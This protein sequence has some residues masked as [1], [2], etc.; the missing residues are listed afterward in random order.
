PSDFLGA[1]PA[2]Y[3][4]KNGFGIMDSDLHV[5]EPPDLYVRYV[6]PAYR[7][8]APRFQKYD[9]T[10]RGLSEHGVGRW[11]I[12]GRPYPAIY[13]TA[14]YQRRYASLTA[15][16]AKVPE[17]MALAARGFDAAATLEGMDL[18]GVD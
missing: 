9:A 5:M 8:R 12:D 17:H 16:K 10:E 7:E 18:E 14:R 15:E 1:R 6:E 3:P 4:M 2:R 13:D 11:V